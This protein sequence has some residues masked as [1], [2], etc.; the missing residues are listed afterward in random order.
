L[1]PR[2]HLGNVGAVLV[3]AA[4]SVIRWWA[5]LGSAV[6]LGDEGIYLDAFREVAEGRPANQIS[7]FYYPPISAEV[8]AIVVTAIG[9]QATRVLLRLGS[10]LGLAMSV[11]LSFSLWPA[12]RRWRLAVGL[13]YVTF[14]P[15]VRYGITAGNASFVVS[16]MILTGLTFWSVRPLIS[17]LLLGGSVGIKPLAPLSIAALLTHRPVP[18]SGRNWLAGGVA[19]ALAGALLASTPTYLTTGAGAVDRLPF[20][21]SISLN[22]ILTLLDLTVSPLL[23][24]CVIAAVIV[25]IGRLVPMSRAELL[26]FGGVAA[27]LAV[28]IIWSHTLVLTL[29]AQVLALRLAVERR[30]RAG[31]FATAGKVGGAGEVWRRYELVFVCLAVAALQLTEGAGAIDDRPVSF[32]AFILTGA[33]LAAPVLMFYILAAARRSPGPETERVPPQSGIGTKGSQLKK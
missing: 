24:A 16:G 18:W 28:P 1:A 20:I 13:L 25:L 31:T 9:D 3:L 32:Q 23:V 22:R 6:P 30:R 21:R 8:G 7:G 4:F 15:A 14:A 33:Y 12:A 10:V 17:G 19:A 27:I 2:E 26:C 11:W 29:P 5:Y